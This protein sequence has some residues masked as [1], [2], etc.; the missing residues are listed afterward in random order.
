M[1]IGR[2]DNQASNAT[3]ENMSA[4]ATTHAKDRETTSVTLYQL[5]PAVISIHHVELS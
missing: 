4:E 1:L 2:E 5:S 3:P